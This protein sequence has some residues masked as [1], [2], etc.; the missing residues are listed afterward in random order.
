M[1]GLFENLGLEP[2]AARVNVLTHNGSWPT[3]I[4]L[5]LL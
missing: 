4:K 3:A 2:P 1:E 5:N